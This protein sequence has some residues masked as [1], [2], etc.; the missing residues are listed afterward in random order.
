[1][2][3]DQKRKIEKLRKDA[4]T[5]ASFMEIKKFDVEETC[6]K[7]VSVFVEIGM[8]GDE[9]NIFSRLYNREHTLVF[10]GKR[11]GMKVPHSRQLKNGKWTHGYKPYTSFFMACRDYNAR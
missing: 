3:P 7:F 10:I 5:Y 11:G 4:E 2:T 8:I 1:M 6:S 9:D